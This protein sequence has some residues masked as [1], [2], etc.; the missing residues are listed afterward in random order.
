M[1]K[2]IEDKL[3]AGAYALPEEVIEAGLKTLEHE[4]LYG[5]FEPGELDALI[6][7]GQRD[8]VEGRYED[9]EI[10]FRRLRERSRARRVG[11]FRPPGRALRIPQATSRQ[12]SPCASAAP[13]PQPESPQQRRVL[14]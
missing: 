6:A 1:Q 5:D 12:Y 2:L 13:S 8:L 11:Q 14:T 9:G 10:V 4:D 7:E 3:R